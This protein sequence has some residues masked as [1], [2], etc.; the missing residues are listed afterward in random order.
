MDRVSFIQ[1]RGQKVLLLDYSNLNDERE[2]LAMIE[3]RMLVVSEQEPESLLVLTDVTGARIPHAAVEKAKQAAVLDRPFVKRAAIVGA[4]SD[5]AK[6]LMDAVKT[7][8]LREWRPFDTR[9]EAL[10]WLVSEEAGETQ[11]AKAG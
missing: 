11:G 5:R 1:H 7:F 9:P 8:S 6:L 10:D 2:I 3:R 4:Q